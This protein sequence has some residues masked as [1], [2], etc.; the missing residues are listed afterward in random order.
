MSEYREAQKLKHM[1]R[2]A[3][4]AALRQRERIQARYKAKLKRQDAVIENLRSIDWVTGQ[5]VTADGNANQAHD[6]A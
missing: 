6:A 1:Q 3:L 5:K 4:S 2:L